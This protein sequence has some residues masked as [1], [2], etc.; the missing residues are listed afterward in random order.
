MSNQ[1]PLCFHF[2]GFRTPLLHS[3]DKKIPVTGDFGSQSHKRPF[4][5]TPQDFGMS[6]SS[7]FPHF[8]NLERSRSPPIQYDED[9]LQNPVSDIVER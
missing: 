2:P 3:G 5:S 9:F 6:T 8:Q 1:Q 7:K 4:P